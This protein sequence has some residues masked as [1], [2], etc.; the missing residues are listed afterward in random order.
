MT[1][2]N[3]CGRVAAFAAVL[4]IATP[5]AACAA[6]ARDTRS[7]GLEDFPSPLVIGHRGGG[8]G[9]L[10][11]HTLEAYAL[12]IELGADFVEPDLVATKDGVL[13]ARHEPNMIGTTDVASRPEFADRR[14]T[15]MIDGVPDTGFFASDF[16]LAE[17]KTLRA[18]QRLA[19]RDQRFN[20]FYEIPTLD[21]VIA[22]AKRKAREKDRPIGI[23]PETKHP[24]YHQQ[25]GLPLEDRL[26]AALARAG[27][28]NRRAPVFV[29]SFEQANLKYIRSKSSVKL[30]QLIDG[31]DTA[32]DGTVVFQA[33]SLRPF[34]W[35]VAGR[36]DTYGYLVT[37]RGLAE[38][39]TYADGIGP[40]KRY[41]VS[42][43]GVDRDGDGRADDTNGD[44]AVDDSDKDA[45]RPTSV[46][47]D[48]HRLGLMVH[49][50]TFRNEPRYLARDYGQQPTSEYIQFYQLGVDGLF[51]DMADTAFAARAMAKLLASRDY[52]KCL[53]L[54]EKRGRR[55]CEDD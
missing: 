20:G 52:A 11:E 43:A 38:V 46:V 53:V 10:P 9:Y 55:F 23:Y 37:R 35:T 22:F 2:R 21:E 17:I 39:K 25:I 32:L 44:G 15:V 26:L 40:W 24:T 4:A 1:M 47:D 8:S 16:T 3:T 7:D 50:F 14:K 33:P 34:D 27:W 49:P 13:I 6:S 54:G 45:T 29:Q 5:L 48:A 28:N 36:T 19:F 30:I 51:S 41:I 42:V 31:Y 12:G 18:T